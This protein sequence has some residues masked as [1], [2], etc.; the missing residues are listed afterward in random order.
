MQNNLDKAIPMNMIEMPRSAGKKRTESFTFAILKKN[1]VSGLKA[2]IYF[3]YKLYI[4]IMIVPH[5]NLRYYQFF[6]FGFENIK[7]SKE[8]NNMYDFHA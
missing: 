6:L 7:C 4:T 8:A 3:S 2:L 5:I 1:Y